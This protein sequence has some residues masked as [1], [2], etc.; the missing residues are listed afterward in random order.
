MKDISK[1][2]REYL[3]T[4]GAS[5]VGFADLNGIDAAAKM[6]Y[7]YGISIA[8]AL[9]PNIIAGIKKHPT[10]EYY[11]EYLRVNKLLDKLALSAEMFFKDRGI[12]AYALTSER[13]EVDEATRRSVLPHKTTATRAGMG[14]IGK[15]A[16]LVNE[17]YG[18]A[19]RIT[20]VLTDYHLDTGSP[21]NESNCGKCEKCKE[22]CP[23]FAVL[24]LNWTYEMDR[25]SFFRALDCRKTA[26]DRASK[27]N[28]ENSICGACIA[29]CPWTERYI[30]KHID[31]SGG[32]IHASSD[33]TCI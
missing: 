11:E 27:I 16:L 5:L 28:V 15:C 31:N 20:T 3:L 12:N 26:R 8:A 14:W 25:D 21:V 6:G 13:V 19:I 29:A 7:R 10:F 1:E 30:Y 22:A 9:K 32:L 33:N 4:E 17:E 24:G 23:A 2:I 18:S